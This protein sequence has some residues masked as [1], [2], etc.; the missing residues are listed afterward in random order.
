[1]ELEKLEAVLRLMKAYGVTELKIGY[2]TAAAIHMPGAAASASDA[3]A[4]NPDRGPQ[5]V[6]VGDGVKVD[7]DLFAAVGS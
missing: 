4:P 3:V 5:M 7:A 2:D 1:M 6:D